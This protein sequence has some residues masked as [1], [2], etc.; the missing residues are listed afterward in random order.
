MSRPF[1]YNDENFTV[2]GNMLFVHFTDSEKRSVGEPVL[3]VPYEIYRRLKSFTNTVIFSA[4]IT[5]NSS[6]TIPIAIKLFNEK[7]FITFLNERNESNY[8][9]YFYCIFCSKT[10]KELIIYGIFL[11]QPEYEHPL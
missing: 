4:P 11:P 7:P 5:K 6:Y 9:R 2:I 3:E 10:F 8:I 1:S